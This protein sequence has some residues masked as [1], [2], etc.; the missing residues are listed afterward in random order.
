[1]YVGFAY[2]CSL[3]SFG[4]WCRSTRHSSYKF[5]IVSKISDSIHNSFVLCDF[6]VHFQ[7]LLVI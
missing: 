4:A 1:M 3:L 2:I 7:I 6:F 5:T